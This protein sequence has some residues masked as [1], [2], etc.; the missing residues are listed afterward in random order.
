MY[1][2]VEKLMLNRQNVEAVRAMLSDI[3]NQFGLLEKLYEPLCDDEWTSATSCS[4]ANCRESHNEFC[5]HVKDWIE[6]GSET[7]FLKGLEVK[8]A[9]TPPRS[10]RSVSTTSSIRSERMKSR[11][12]LKLAAFAKQQEVERVS[13]TRMRV[14]KQAEET[15]RAAIEEAEKLRL[16]MEAESKRKLREAEAETQR[17]L[18]E[19]EAKAE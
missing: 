17:K 1:F 9:P 8:S 12:K 10:E 7:L 15:K 5:E 16:E 2:D 6:R 18:R 11:A 19:A 3:S 14:K 13:E 4:K